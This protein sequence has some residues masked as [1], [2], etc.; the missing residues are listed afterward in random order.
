MILATASSDT[1][2]A[3]PSRTRSRAATCRSAAKR[4]IQSQES[5]GPSS[6]S[7]LVGEGRGGGSASGG[8]AVPLGLTGRTRLS[9]G[10]GG[11]DNDIDMPI[12]DLELGLAQ[13]K[14]F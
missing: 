3:S 6:P 8:A 7:P 5:S 4:L 2:E 12:G 1:R 11:S 9:G 14:A 13:G 10:T